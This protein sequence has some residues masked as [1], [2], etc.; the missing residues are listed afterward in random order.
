[1]DK[2]MSDDLDFLKKLNKKDREIFSNMTD[3]EKKMAITENRLAKEEAKIQEENADTS[4]LTDR[5]ASKSF[6]G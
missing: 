6:Q 5:I 4:Q 3:E 2:N 1:M